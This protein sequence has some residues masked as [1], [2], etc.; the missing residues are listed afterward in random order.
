MI[1]AM[2]S[3]KLLIS[4][5]TGTIIIFS[6]QQPMYAVDMKEALVM[7]F[8]SMDKNQD[9]DSNGHDW[10]LLTKD[11]KINIVSFKV[12]MFYMLNSGLRL[13]QAW[14]PSNEMKK[15]MTR[16]IYSTVNR[17]DAFYKAQK[18]RKYPMS[19]KIDSIIEGL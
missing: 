11:E 1:T 18:N 17:M 9:G 14:N 13:D 19:E 4:A 7:I 10:S 15:K 16:E 3:Y 8:Q 5:I 6:A 2:N 12:Q